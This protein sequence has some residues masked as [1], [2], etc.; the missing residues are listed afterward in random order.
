[1]VEI[2]RDTIEEAF[3]NGKNQVIEH[4]QLHIAIG[5]DLQRQ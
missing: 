3:D 4:N 5:K 2:I 1:M